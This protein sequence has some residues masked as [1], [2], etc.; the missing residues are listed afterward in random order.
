MLSPHP[1]VLV[2]T[3][4]ILPSGNCWASMW[5]GWY[6]STRVPWSLSPQRIFSPP[7]A[8]HW[9]TTSSF[10]SVCLVALLHAT[11]RSPSKPLT[12]WMSGLWEWR[13]EWSKR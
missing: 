2:G 3:S 5:V 13:T 7:L 6:V 12:M 1:L 4:F 8:Y 10:H 9:P 11:G